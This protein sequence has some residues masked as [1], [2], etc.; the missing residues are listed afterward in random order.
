MEFNFK[1]KLYDSD[2]ITINNLKSSCSLLTK[3]LDSSN[4]TAPSENVTISNEPFS[5]QSYLSQIKLNRSTKEYDPESS[6]LESN[7]RSRTV[8]YTKDEI[9]DKNERIKKLEKSL[10]NIQSNVELKR[11]NILENIYQKINL[12]ENKIAEGETDTNA[13]LTWISKKVSQTILHK[14]IHVT[15]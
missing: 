1:S 12:L 10:S 3:D 13:R 9:I 14:I 15:D 7:S 6:E 2:K 4:S 8:D 11:S 5:L